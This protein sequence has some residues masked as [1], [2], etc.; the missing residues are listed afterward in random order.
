MLALK[1]VSLEGYKSIK[2][3]HDLELRPLNVMIGANGTGKS[4]FLSF[5]KLLNFS[6]TGALQEFIGRNGGAH[7]LLF[8]GP[9]VTPQFSAT[10]SIESDSGINTY[11][12]RLV[13]A[14]PDTLIYGEESLRYQAHDA[15]APPAKPQLVK[16]GHRETALREPEY[17]KNPTAKFFRNTLSRFRFYQFHDTSDESRLRGAVDKDDA[18]CLYANAGNLAAILRKLHEA[19]PAQ[20]QRIVET[21][22]MAA[23]F[24]DD[25]A[26]TPDIADSRYITLRWKSKGRAEYVFGP[27]QLSDGTLRFMAL[28]TLLLQP[29]SW[30]PALIVLDEPELGLHPFALELLAGLLAEASAETQIIVSTQSSAFLDSFEPEDILVAQIKEEASHFSRLNADELK[31]WLSEYSLGEL[32]RKNVIE[33]GPQP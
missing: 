2:S 6:M 23:P 30:R 8:Y 15:P 4:N 19:A 25:F 32:V 3:C 31:Q 16:S 7:S 18:T 9:R 22:R 17:A 10:L 12:C 14:A 13:H 26:L 28:C 29:P 20:Y 21:V 27:H 1:K 24:F 11:H 33:A 5:F